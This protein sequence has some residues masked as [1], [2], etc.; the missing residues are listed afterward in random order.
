MIDAS[1]D[2]P[3]MATALARRAADA[4]RVAAA[5]KLA[6]ALAPRLCRPAAVALADALADARAAPG[7]GGGAAIVAK[8]AEAKLRKV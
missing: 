7:V 6:A 3:A 4:V 8:S 1:R 5:G 2:A